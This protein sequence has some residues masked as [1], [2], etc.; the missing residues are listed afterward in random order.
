MILFSSDAVLD[1]D[2]LRNFLEAR[3][4]EAAKRALRKI[5]RALELAEHLPD[6]GRATEDPDIR[7]LTVPFGGGAY[8]V[9]YRNFPDKQTVF[10]T[11]LWHSREQRE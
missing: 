4:P 2:R 10:V 1:V 7:Q 6:L 11:R 8:I 5:W 3:N 9:R